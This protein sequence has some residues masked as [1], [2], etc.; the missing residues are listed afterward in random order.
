[1]KFKMPSF[2]KKKSKKVSKVEIVSLV[3]MVLCATSL[4]IA[5]RKK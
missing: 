4:L 5:F 3:G 1:M 2:P